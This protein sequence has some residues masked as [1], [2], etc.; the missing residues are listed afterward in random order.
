ML[1][2]SLNLQSYPLKV[3]FAY[4]SIDALIGQNLKRL[5]L[6]K[7]LSQDALAEMVQIPKSLISA[8]ENDKRGIG[9]DIMTRICKALNVQP[10]EFYLD[11]NTPL[12]ATELEKKAL[13]MAR[14]AG[15]AKLDYIAEEIV[16]YGNQRIERLK[17]EQKKAGSD[18]SRAARLKAG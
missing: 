11:E 10:Y 16:E 17:K 15:S 6:L 4:M 5:R 1:Y 2:N 18:K 7:G 9:K 8:A 12:P 3:T 14:A 13:F